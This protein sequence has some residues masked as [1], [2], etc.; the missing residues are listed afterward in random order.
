MP[1]IRIDE[2]VWSY[3]KSKA[4]PF[5]D[6]PNDVLRRELKMSGTQDSSKSASQPRNSR[7]RLIPGKDYSHL[8][9]T[10]YRL[11]KDGQL[12]PCRSFSDM[13]Q[14]VSNSLCLKHMDSFPAAALQ[15]HG[16]K[17]PY[18][19]KNPGDLRKP[20]KLVLGGIYVETNLSANSI[21]GVSRLLLE[22]LGYDPNAL[23]VQ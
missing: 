11:Q 19:S 1:T 20:Q 23:E 15:L 14:T 21:V 4:T 5:E 7:A 2:E 16:K 13:L 18:F 10:G 17:R 12:V 9:I 3:L 22:K 8:Q 6:T